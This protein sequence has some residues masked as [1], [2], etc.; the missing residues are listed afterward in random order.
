MQLHLDMVLRSAPDL[1]IPSLLLKSFARNHSLQP[2]LTQ[3]IV[4][5]AFPFPVLAQAL[6]MSPVTLMRCFFFVV[7]AAHTSYLSK[8]NNGENNGKCSVSEADTIKH[9]R[10]GAS[11]L[12]AQ[13]GSRNSD[14][15]HPALNTVPQ[16][17]SCQYTR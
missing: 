2:V 16:E 11:A 1:H 12:I 3:S 13:T 4:P 17:G 8:S 7:V 9:A 5:A 10:L 15:Q 6:Q 14:P